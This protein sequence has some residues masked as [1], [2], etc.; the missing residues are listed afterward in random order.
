MDRLISCKRYSFQ[1][2][3]VWYDVYQAQDGYYAEITSNRDEEPE[4]I[5][6]GDTI[7][8]CHVKVKRMIRHWVES[9]EIDELYRR[10][11]GIEPDFDDIL[12]SVRDKNIGYH[13]TETHNLE[14][15]RNLGLIPD[16]LNNY[17]VSEASLYMDQYKPEGI[18][19]WVVRR[20]AVYAYPRLTNYH[21]KD[22]SR[23]NCIL[24]AVSI[25][26]PFQCWVG[27]Q[28]YGG[29]CLFHDRDF[30]DREYALQWRKKHIREIKRT[31]IREY[32]RYSCSLQ[33]FITTPTYDYDEIL[34]FRPIAPELITVIGSW[35]AD[36]KFTKNESFRDFVRPHLKDTYHEILSKY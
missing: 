36:G 12:L 3:I 11:Y 34:I 33:E 28:G 30:E 13:I 18:P 23:E 27:D 9:G 21:I 19:S 29:L 25:P 31:H 5:V 15:I 8:S 22:G 24:L 35:G 32:W 26:D 14:S 1:R 17:S 4:I 2:Y 20:Q 7:M 10:E 6:H 16:F